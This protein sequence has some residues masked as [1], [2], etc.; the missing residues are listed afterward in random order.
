[1]AIHGDVLPKHLTGGLSL[2]RTVCSYLAILVSCVVGAALLTAQEGTGSGTL[3]VDG[4]TTSLGHVVRT[5]KPNL[6]NDFF[7][8]TVVVLSNKP[9]TADEAADDATLLARARHGELVTIAV[10]F[11][12]RPRRGQLFNIALTHQ[13]LVETLLLPD[14]WVAYTFKAGAGT[15]KMESREISGRTYSAGAEFSVPMPAET[16]VDDEAPVRSALPPPST[17]EAERQA[18]SALLIEALQEGDEARALAIVELGIDPNAR[19][20]KMGIALINWAVLMCQ[21]PVVRALVELKADLTHER[22]P[23]MT[24][25][26]EAMAA[27]PDAVGFLRAGGA[28]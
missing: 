12:G 19:D 10:R 18:A 5:T 9:L 20:E 15:L 7:S 21:P 24:L 13:G 23:G 16:S 25:L 8:D 6:F 3:T 27:C 4:V 17:T 2:F 11:D 22:L 26:A 28:K 1:V 14:V